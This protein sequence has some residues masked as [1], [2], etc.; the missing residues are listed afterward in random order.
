MC[1]D[2]FSA[3]QEKVMTDVRRGMPSVQLDRQ[4]F[5]VDRVRRLPQI[6]ARAESGAGLRRSRF[7][8]SRRVA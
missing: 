6:A 1:F 8:H 2:A 5:N 3:R 7:W 4:E